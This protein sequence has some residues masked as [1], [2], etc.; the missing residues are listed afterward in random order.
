MAGWFR[1]QLNRFTL[2]RSRENHSV[3]VPK[4]HVWSIGIYSGKDPINLK[5][6]KGIRNPVLTW[7]SV[8]DVPALFV[9]DPFMVRA[10]HTWYMF[11]EVM[12]RQSEKGEI[13]LATS[14]DALH[15][16][17]KQI[18]LAEPFHLS[19]PYVFGWENDYY[20]VPETYKAGAVR[21]YKAVEFPTHWSFVGELLTGPY[22]ADSCLLRFGDRWWLFTEASSV[23]NNDTLRL[24]SSAHIS[25]PFVEHP[26]SPIIAGN[27]HIAR[28]AGRIVSYQGKA[29]RYAQDCNPLYG[30]HVRA[31]EISELTPSHYVERGLGEE[32]V[33]GPTGSGWNES[34]M[35]HI[36]PHIRDDGLWVACVDGFWLRPQS[37]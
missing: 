35:H 34:G 19:Y 32:P 17:Y 18:V 31:F 28:P 6:V 22:F 2:L 16:R 14:Q 23:W 11:F 15:W 21:L 7:K 27:P 3:A 4:Q 37:R 5:P 25:G 13:G 33:L 1:R 29:I 9:A 24:Y 12:N 20:M 36:D 8:S 26:S 30:T 10:D